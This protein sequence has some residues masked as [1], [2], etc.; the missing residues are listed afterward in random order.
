MPNATASDDVVCSCSYSIGDDLGMDGA[1]NAT[2]DVFAE[3]MAVTSVLTSAASGGC[4][5]TGYTVLV[6]TVAPPSD[7]CGV[8]GGSGTSCLDTCGVANGDD[9]SCAGDCGVP[10]GG[11]S[12]CDDEGVSSEFFPCANATAAVAQAERQAARIIADS[13]SSLGMFGGS[14]LCFNGE[15]T[16]LISVFSGA[17]EIQSALSALGTVGE[18]RDDGGL[19]VIGLMNAA[20]ATHN[21]TQFGGATE[22]HFGLTF[23]AVVAGV[24]NAPF[25]AGPLRTVVELGHIDQVTNL[26]T[27]S[28]E[29]VCSGSYA[30]GYDYAEQLVSLSSSANLTQLASHGA[31]FKLALNTS[32][33]GCAT[34]G[35]SLAIPLGASALEFMQALLPLAG[36]LHENQ[37]EMFVVNRSAT[38]AAWVVR[39]YT[40]DGTDLAGYTRL[41]RMPALVLHNATTAS[42]AVGVGVS[43]LAAGMVPASAMPVD[44]A[45]LAAAASA[46]S[47][48]LLSSATAVA[49]VIA[50]KKACGNS[51]YVTT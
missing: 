50:V 15:T 48:A 34:A 22:I 11:S 4:L 17:L 29:R 1:T 14:R 43:I 23:R 36:G 44:T 2:A 45:Q 30:S 26:G 7:I 49:E 21:T 37:L 13:A 3:L 32:E 9:S 42:S 19:T 25:N 10:N 40:L 46:A 31:H 8:P 38:R 20:G 6:I 35:T 5:D 39:F 51:L 24:T 18:D 28:A 47:A 27:T 16:D 12:S 41:G 33:A